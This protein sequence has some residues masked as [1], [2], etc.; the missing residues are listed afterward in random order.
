MIGYLTGTNIYEGKDYIIL[1]T[2]AVGYKVHVTPAAKLKKELALFV[3][4]KVTDS[5]I[6]LFGFE[7][8]QQLKVFES[9]IK[10]SGIGPKIAL[11]ILSST[12]T[13][14]IISAISKADVSFFT[15][16]PGLGKKGAQK[17]IVELKNKQDKDLSFSDEQEN[18][19]Y[20]ALLNLGFKSAE[21]NPII[22]KIDTSISLQD[23]IKQSLK[24]LK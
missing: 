7:D 1:N 22:A 2:G 17:I 8:Q 3:H 14:N 16:I 15:A 4:T 19:L 21:I 23:Q 20:Q 9:L 18:D 12:T 13:Q 5:D 11:A 10:V 24:L 6:A